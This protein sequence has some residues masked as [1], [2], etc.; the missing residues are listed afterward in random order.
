MLIKS[1]SLSLRLFSGELV[2]L[3]NFYLTSGNY[4]AQKTIM[5]TVSAQLLTLRKMKDPLF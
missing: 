1:I 5:E 2:L 3:L 4:N